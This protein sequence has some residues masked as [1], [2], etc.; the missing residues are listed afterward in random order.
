MIVHSL[1]F[2]MFT[3][4]IQCFSESTQLNQLNLFHEL[5]LA[6]AIGKQKH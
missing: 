1:K 5:K 4:Q 3:D 6:K 2:D